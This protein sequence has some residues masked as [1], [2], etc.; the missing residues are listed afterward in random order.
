MA[1]DN[2]KVAPILIVVSENPCPLDTTG[3]LM[4][5]DPPAAG[6]GGLNPSPPPPVDPAAG[7]VDPP[8]PPPAR[9]PPAAAVPPPDCA[10]PAGPDDAAF[11]CAGEP[12]VVPAAAAAEFT[13]SATV[14][15]VPSGDRT[16]RSSGAGWPPASAGAAAAG[17][18]CPSPS[19]LCA[20][21]PAWLPQ[22]AASKATT[23]TASFLTIPRTPCSSML[24]FLPVVQPT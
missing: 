17:A 10:P 14:V 5:D 9:E 20:G 6:T 15:G 16:C 18:D 4:G 2:G 21:F 1:P 3:A 24:V 23:S 22:A 7:A 12:G 19:S 8:A 11:F 13:A